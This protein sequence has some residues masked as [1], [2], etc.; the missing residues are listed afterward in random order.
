MIAGTGFA[1]FAA[2]NNNAIM[3][4]VEK[5]HYGLATSLLSTTRLFGQVLSVAMMNL[6]LSLSWH[7]LAP[8][9]ALLQNLEIALLI[10]ALCAGLGVI[11]A[12]VRK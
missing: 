2:P 9:A 8:Q 3:S 11:P 1:L 12:R 6:I 7:G 5:Q 4:S 10:F